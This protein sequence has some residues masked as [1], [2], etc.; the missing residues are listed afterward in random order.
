MILL[1]ET[2]LRCLIF[3][4]IDNAV[5]EDLRIFYSKFSPIE[6][7]VDEFEQLNDGD[8]NF[9]RKDLKNIIDKSFYTEMVDVIK[10][11]QIL[12]GLSYHGVSN[13]VPPRFKFKELSSDACEIFL[14]SEGIINE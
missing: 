3:K 10:F 4:F 1:T 13:H 11:Y 7:D 2:Q 8:K 6:F 5:D 12:G 14:K 9:I